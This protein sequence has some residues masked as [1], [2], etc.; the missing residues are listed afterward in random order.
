M[1]K[2][3]DPSTQF[4][5][6]FCCLY[7]YSPVFWKQPHPMCKWISIGYILPKIYKN[8][9]PEE[10]IVK[11]SGKIMYTLLYLKC[12][13]NKNPYIVHG[14][15]LN[16][17]CQPGWEWGLGENGYMYVHGWVPSLFT[18]NYHNIVNWLFPNIKCIWY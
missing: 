18:W 16:I 3:T 13:T 1:I 15:L 5:L 9:C 8:S 4:W 6:L 12:I 11:D 7:N 14:T 17:M 2:Q 10:G